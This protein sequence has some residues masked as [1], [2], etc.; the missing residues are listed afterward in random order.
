V[1]GDLKQTCEPM[2]LGAVLSHMLQEF[3][4]ANREK[5]ID[6]ARQRVSERT[7]PK[8]ADT[9]LEHGVPILLTQIV[10]ALARVASTPTL[11]LVGSAA[12]R[13][14]IADTAGLHGQEL[15]RNG[16]TVGQVVNG[17]GD[18]CQVVTELAG[19]ANVLISTQE[20]H[21][22]NKCLD[23]A[24][25]SAVTAFGGQRER[26][27]A[28][29]GTERL[30]VLAHEMRNLLNTM[31]LSLTII[32]EGKVGLGGSTGAMLV[33][34]VSALSALVDRSVAE[35]RLEAGIARLQRVSMVEFME[36][37]K[38]SG[39]LH[40]E[41]YGLQ[42]TMHPVDRDL[43]IDADWHLLASAV[44]NLLQN[45]FKFSRAHG[46]V[47]LATRV[48]ADRVLIDV[49]DECGGLPPGKAQNLF[50]PFTQASADRSGLG[51]GLAIALS[52]ARANA[53]DIHVRD[54]PGTGCV[55]TIDLPRRPSALAAAIA[56]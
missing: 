14:E 28:Y 45:A 7:A 29:E 27:L 51:L 19:E 9:N 40:A 33:R 54:I 17:Y 36:E 26:D 11:H 8:S 24:I 44:S 6:R 47:S 18:V 41:G 15:L 30:G 38:V 1:A 32:R 46:H 13:T 56:I 49:C 25:A 53:G 12:G 39:A 22:F 55:F 42:F 48:T 52:A 10:D 35:V 16:L 50:R 34:S 2:S 23:Q 4:A 43:M 20:F 5:I 31:T 21:A 3:I 37:M